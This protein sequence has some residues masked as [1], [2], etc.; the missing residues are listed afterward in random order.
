MLIVFQCL[1]AEELN[2]GTKDLFETAS[3]RKLQFSFTN[4]YQTPS[5]TQLH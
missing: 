2:D 3:L 4:I 1:W 5:T